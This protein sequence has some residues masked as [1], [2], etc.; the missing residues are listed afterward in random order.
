M[1]LFCDLHNQ[2]KV[3]DRVYLDYRSPQFIEKIANADDV[4]VVEDGG[5]FLDTD[6]YDEKILRRFRQIDGM[7]VRKEEVMKRG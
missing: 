2:W 3:G 5:V 7:I 1:F 6:R 4:F